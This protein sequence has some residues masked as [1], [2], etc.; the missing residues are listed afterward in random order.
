VSAADSRLTAGPD[1]TA[2]LAGELA[3]G[4]RGGDV[5]FLLGEV[6]SGKTTFVRA[7][8]RALG[9]GAPV[10][11]PSFTL[12]QR[13]EDGRLPVSHLDFQRLGGGVEDPSLFADEIS[14]E[15]VTF[16]EWAGEA[17]EGIGWSPDWV[18]EL[19]HAGDDRRRVTVRREEGR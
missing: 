11:S 13:Y 14:P 12:A 8:C 3:G 9:V 10:T 4:L 2:A 19:E 1:E 5:V 7:A 16:V 17:P 15:R 6:G 18:V